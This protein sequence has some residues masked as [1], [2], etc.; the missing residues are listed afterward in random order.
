M[1]VVKLAY[2]LN[3]NWHSLQLNSFHL[4]KVMTS[5]LFSRKSSK[6]TNGEVMLILHVC[7]KVG[8][9]SDFKLAFVAIELFLFTKGW[10]FEA[11]LQY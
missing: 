11:V 8:I 3:L 6:N 7:C 4:Q 9:F 2:F 10:N 1:C 5:E